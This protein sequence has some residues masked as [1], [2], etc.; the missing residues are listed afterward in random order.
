[1]LESGPTAKGGKRTSPRCEMPDRSREGKKSIKH[2]D[3]GKKEGETA[4]NRKT[5][6]FPKFAKKKGGEAVK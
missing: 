5:G 3:K 1:M 4:A 2:K 6:L